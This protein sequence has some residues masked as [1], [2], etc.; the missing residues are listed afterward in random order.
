MLR[1]STVP[2]GL[3]DL[4]LDD[5]G[6]TTAIID[7]P[8]EHDAAAL[9]V[10]VPE[11]VL[12]EAESEWLSLDTEQLAFLAAIDGAENVAVVAAR[13]GI[14]ANRARTLVAELVRRGVVRFRGSG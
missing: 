1:D 3:D 4:S 11:R 14:D 9:D 2:A 8:S 6:E 5:S 13:V 10:R 12:S 7:R